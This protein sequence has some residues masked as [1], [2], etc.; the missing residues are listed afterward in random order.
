[1]HPDQLAHCL[2]DAEVMEMVKKAQLK[3]VLI[4]GFPEIFTFCRGD[5]GKS[6]NSSSATNETEVGPPL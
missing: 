6:V 3:L 2:R 4:D 5:A 1:M